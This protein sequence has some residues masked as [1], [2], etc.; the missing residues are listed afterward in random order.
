MKRAAN[1]VLMLGIL[2]GAS[3]GLAAGQACGDL[4]TA[5][6][7]APQKM[8]NAKGQ[9][10][11]GRGDVIGNSVPTI[12]GPKILA[13][14]PV[15]IYDVE[16]VAKLYGASAAR[17]DVAAEL[18]ATYKRMLDIGG[19]RFTMMATRLDVLDPLYEL[20]PNFRPVLDRMKRSIAISV[21]AGEP[22]VQPPIVLLGP[23]GVGKTFFG[24]RLAEAIGSGYGF[25]PMN[26]TTAGWILSGTYST[27]KGAT[28]GKV[29]RI[30]IEGEFANPVVLVDEIDKASRSREY[31][32]L[33]SFYQLWE[34]SSKTFVDEYLQ[35]PVDA[36]RI[37]WIATANYKDQIPTPI[38]DRA[39]VIEVPAPN[40]DQLRI[41]V[42]YVLKNFLKKHPGLKFSD[43]LPEEVFTVLEKH[44]P[45][46]IRKMIEDAVGG[47]LLANRTELRAVD[48]DKA[49]VENSDQQKNPIGFV[50]AR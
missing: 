1:V 10:I 47:A 33:A 49:I 41:I 40:R 21:A 16:Q 6:I 15:R 25:I 50:P 42:G 45:R 3:V 22:I 19:E 36:S 26:T 7:L 27:W 29:A 12:S 2:V 32:A 44:T 48:V 39:I 4:F 8:F 38:L 13:G 35:V 14:L 23:P 9:E 24:E 43:N 31:D 20:M 46:D 28:M 11:D 5:R 30:L 17:G 37:N 18:T 34:T